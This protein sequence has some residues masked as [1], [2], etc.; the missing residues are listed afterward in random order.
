MGKKKDI[1]WKQFVAEHQKSGKTVV[2]FCKEKGI[3]PNSF[4]SARK[5]CKHGGEQD[6]K[7]HRSRNCKWLCED[8]NTK[9]GGWFRSQRKSRLCNQGAYKILLEKFGLVKVTNWPKLL[10][11]VNA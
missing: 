4:Y 8:L 11:P 3:H 7:S 2:E 5:I 1:N 10:T 6:L 9:I